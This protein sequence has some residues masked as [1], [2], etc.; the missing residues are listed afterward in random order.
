MISL[1]SAILI[2]IISILILSLNISPGGNNFVVHYKALG[3]IDLFGSRGDVYYPIF[4]GAIILIINV[5]LGILFWSRI[6]KLSY[7][8]IA[9]LPVLEIIIL[10][11][12]FN[13]AY[14]NR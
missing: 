6:R 4:A 8:A 14:I 2:F 3:G 10:I 11:T 13:L 1:S 5:F 12:C 7:L 9:S